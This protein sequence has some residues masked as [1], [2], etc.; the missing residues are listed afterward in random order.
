MQAGLPVT[1]NY[2]ATRAGM[3]IHIL[4]KIRVL[5]VSCRDLSVIGL[6]FR[7]T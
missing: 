6:C 2:A 1:A 7:S 5:F 4:T 3:A